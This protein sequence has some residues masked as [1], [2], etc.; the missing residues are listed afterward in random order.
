MSLA[1]SR[2]V[3]CGA[4]G[5]PSCP[6]SIGSGFWYANELETSTGA[7][8][9]LLLTRVSGLSVEAPSG[10]SAPRFVCG[11]RKSEAKSAAA[12]MKSMG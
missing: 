6:C 11:D 8:R 7:T 2:D 12:K 10:D 3:S 1:G 5:A 9:G 4:A